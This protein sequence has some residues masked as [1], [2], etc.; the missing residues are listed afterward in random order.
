MIFP[1]RKITEFQEFLFILNGKY[2]VSGAQ[3]VDFFAG[4]LQQ[5]YDETVA[6]LKNLSGDN[7]SCGT[8]GCSI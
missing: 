5:T 1:K 4:A 3:P 7:N 2:A 6:P 8:D